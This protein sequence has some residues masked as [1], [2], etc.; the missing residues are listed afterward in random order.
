[1]S[2]LGWFGLYYNYCWF[3]WTSRCINDAGSSVCLLHSEEMWRQCTA[4]WASEC[5]IYNKLVTAC[6]AFRHVLENTKHVSHC[7]C[8]QAAT[9]DVISL[10]M[11]TLTSIATIPFLCRLLAD[12]ADVSVTAANSCAK[13]ERVQP[14]RQTEAAPAMPAAIPSELW[15]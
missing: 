4:C 11:S 7:A 2:N 9:A 10:S 8:D 6:H 3:L 12:R 5:V 15:L 14:Q 13:L 1:M